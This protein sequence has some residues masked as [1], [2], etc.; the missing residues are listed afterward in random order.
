MPTTAGSMSLE[1]M[2][3]GKDAFVVKRLRD[4]GAVILAKANMHEFA[5]SQYETVSSILPGYTRNPYDI[6]RVTAGSSGGTAAAVAANFGAIGLGTDTGASIRGPASFQA[7]VGIRPTMGLTSRAGVVPVFL[8][9][10][11][12][13]PLTRTVADLAAVLQ[14]I[15]GEDPADAETAASRGWVRPMTVPAGERRP[16]RARGLACG[17]KCPTRRRLTPKSRA[18]SL[19]RSII[20]VTPAPRWLIRLLST[21]WTHC[22]EVSAE[23]WVQPVQVRPEPLSRRSGREGADALARRNRQVAPVPPD[24]SNAA[25]NGA[26]LERRPWPVAWLSRARRVPGEI[27]DGRAEAHGRRAARRGR[28]PDLEQPAAAH[29]PSQHAGRRQQPAVSRRAQAF[30]LLPCRWA[31]PAAARCR[32]GSKSSA[33]RG[34]KRR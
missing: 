10:D 32:P 2:M 22:G 16:G 4:A 20:F 13:G 17:T 21:A 29:R 3:T 6:S 12:T 27:A 24:D 26:G 14:V 30:Q 8:D 11:V 7:L 5:F 34:A 33:G 1:G 31:I 19:W 25:R 23:R 9:S 18:S 28:G 15:A